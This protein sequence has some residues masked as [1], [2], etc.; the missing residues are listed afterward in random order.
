MPAFR[1][2]HALDLVVQ[3]I[4]RIGE[5]QQ[6]RLHDLRLCGVQIR[7]ENLLLERIGCVDD[8]LIASG[9]V[10]GV[11]VFANLL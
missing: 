10:L 1:T 2:P 7:P 6:F 11:E 5:P 9:V 4:H 3:T 8:V